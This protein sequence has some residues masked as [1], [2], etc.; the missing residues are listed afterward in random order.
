MYLNLN[1][2][3]NMGNLIVKDN[4]L[5]EASHKLSEIEQRLILLAILKAREYCDSVEELK[6]KKLIIHADDYINTFGATRQGAY[7]A[8]RQAVMGLY[9]AEWG[10][11]YINKKGSKVVC[12][13]RFTQSAEYIEAEA[14]V[15][16]TFAD[17]IIPMLVELEKRFTTYEIEQVAQLSSSYAMR[18]YEFFMQHLDKKIGKGWLEISLEDLRF[19]FGILPTEYTL[20]SNFKN[21]VLDYSI[22]DINKHTDLS[23]TY[24]QKKQG[25]KITGFRFD[26][27]R[28]SK[29]Q[30]NDPTQSTSQKE[31]GVIDP[32]TGLTDEER[33]VI[34]LKFNEYI[35][36]LQDKGELVND[37][38]RKNITNKAITE[39]W[40]IAEYQQQQAQEQAEKERHAQELAKQQAEAKRQQQKVQKQEAEN[41]AFVEYFESLPQDEQ[42][43]II[44]EVGNAI[45]PL[46]K[47]YFDEAVANSTAHKDLMYRGFFRQVMEI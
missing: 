14:T 39:K 3:N 36:Y 22:N 15:S 28:K 2:R 44:G 35:N 27:K 41:R 12:Y 1:T 26:F 37:F 23:A 38:H 30:K 47:E 10:Y 4:A 18:L 17:A 43:R 31:A 40:G 19:R 16:F 9:R 21:R 8:L 25:R 45:A 42:N 13:E 6:G 32:F 11:K 24:T 33:K 29:P 7:K 46:F 34:E 5:I 20:M